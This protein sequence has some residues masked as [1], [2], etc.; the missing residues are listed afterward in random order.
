MKVVEEFR[1][2]ADPY[3]AFAAR[4]YGVAEDAVSAEMRDAVKALLFADTYATRRLS[5]RNVGLKE[6]R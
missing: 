3:R 1:D 2:S 6:D 5:L 4:W